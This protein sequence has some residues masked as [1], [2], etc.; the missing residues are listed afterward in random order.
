MGRYDRGLAL[1]VLAVAYVG[2]GR[3]YRNENP[4]ALWVRAISGAHVAL[5]FGIAAFRGD[6]PP[7]GWSSALTLTAAV[8]A[9]ILLWRPQHFRVLFIPMTLWSIASIR[10]C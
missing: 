1:R 8:P 5:A 10:V 7:A 6:I 2:L 9:A 3:Y 4:S